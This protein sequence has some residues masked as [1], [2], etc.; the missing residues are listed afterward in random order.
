LHRVDAE[1]EQA[2]APEREVTGLVNPKLASTMSGVPI[3]PAASSSPS[4]W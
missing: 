3:R 1:I 4:R 2:A